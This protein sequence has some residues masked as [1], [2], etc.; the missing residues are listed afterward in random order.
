MN[1]HSEDLLQGEGDVVPVFLFRAAEQ[2]FSGP[3]FL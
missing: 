1:L 3:A 2:K